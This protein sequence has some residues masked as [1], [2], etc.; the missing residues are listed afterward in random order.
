MTGWELY[1]ILKLDDI[2]DLFHGLC[3]PFWVVAVACGI[4][5]AITNIARAVESGVYSTEKLHQDFLERMKRLSSLSAK[6]GLP[7][8]V[9]AIVLVGAKFLL[10]STKQMAALV[11]VPK[12]SNVITQSETLK[13]MPA[14]ILKLAD[15]WVTELSPNKEKK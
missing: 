15:D 2:R 4:V 10:P 14:K 11:V 5:F 7:T 1:W 9:V 6:I 8:V 3:V 13:K 12:V